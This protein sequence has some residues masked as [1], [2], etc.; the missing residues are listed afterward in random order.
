[1]SSRKRPAAISNI[2][3]AEWRYRFL[4]LCLLL[5][6]VL[7]PIV[8]SP[9]VGDLMMA[10]ILLAVIYSV[11]RHR[12][13][14]FAL[15]VLATPLAA[16]LV[17]HNVSTFDQVFLPTLIGG[18]AIAFL[19]F[20]LVV[21]LMDVLSKGEVTTDRLFGA[22]C[23]YLLLGVLWGFIYA[24]LLRF[25][26]S[27]FKGL[28]FENLDESE[29]LIPILV[30]FSFVTISTL[31]YGDITPATTVAGTLAWLESVTGQLYIAILV[32]RLVG[33]HLAAQKREEK[34]QSTG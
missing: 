19:L 7:Y 13:K 5:L 22:M 17:M 18:M 1:M 33:L 3:P 6:A 34:E 20:T 14:L 21:V 11:S 15:C 29:P 30:Y 23:V 27:A 31:G 10:L 9:V 8:H 26:P 32:G 28:D 2:D 24:I 4:F 12:P 25:D 16:S